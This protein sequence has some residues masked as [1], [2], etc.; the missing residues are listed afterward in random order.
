MANVTFHVTFEK[1]EQVIQYCSRNITLC[2]T[3][4]LS[5]SSRQPFCLVHEPSKLVI[6]LF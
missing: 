5:L 3:K 1:N 2:F 6:L 4:T